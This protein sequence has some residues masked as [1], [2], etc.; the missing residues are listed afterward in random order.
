MTFNLWW[1]HFENMLLSLGGPSPIP[2]PSFNPIPWSTTKRIAGHKNRQTDTHTYVLFYFSSTRAYQHYKLKNKIS[3]SGWHLRPQQCITL[4]SRVLPTKL[5]G[6]VTF[7]S[8]S[9]SAWPQLTPSWPL[10]PSIHYTLINGS[11]Y[12][13]W[14]VW[15]PQ[16]IP[17]QFDLCLNLADPYMTF[18]PLNALQG[19][20]PTKFRGHR[21]KQ[22]DPWLTQVNPYMTFDPINVIHFGQGLLLP[23][24]VVIRHSWAIW[25]QVY[26]GWLLHDLWPFSFSNL[27]SGWP[28]TFGL[29]ASNVQHKPISNHPTKSFFYIYID[30]NLVSCMYEALCILPLFNY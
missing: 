21:P 1:C 22:F 17:K 7:L 14:H 24:L 30:R 13:L 23:N 29:V 15:L 8:N 16:D 28:L 20:F 10:T 26:L 19:F 9:N 2:I 18:D 5:G 3:N 27:T 11:F 12:L 6:L 25:P 4:R